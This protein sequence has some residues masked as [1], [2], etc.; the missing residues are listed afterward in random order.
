[1]PLEEPIKQILV[2]TRPLWDRPSTRPAVRESF[3]RMIDCRTPALGWQIYAS[4]TEERR[5]YHTC[6]SKP[7]PSCGYRATLLWQREQW[8]QLPDVPYAGVVFTM[9][10]V[11]LVYF[12]TKPPPCA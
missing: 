10:D 6:K 3:R 12:Q 1:M 5:V 7:C 11:P 2:D 4:E 9:P 8:T